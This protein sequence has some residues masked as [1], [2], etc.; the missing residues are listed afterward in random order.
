M[1]RPPRFYQQTVA[2]E[3]TRPPRSL[4]RVYFAGRPRFVQRME[5]RFGLRRPD[6]LLRRVHTKA[7]VVLVGHRPGRGP[8]QPK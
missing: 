7:G 3:A 1:P 2:D 5:A 8:G 6:T 4:A